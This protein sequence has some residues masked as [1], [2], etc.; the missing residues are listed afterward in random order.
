MKPHVVSIGISGHVVK[1]ASA[2]GAGD[3]GGIKLSPGTAGLDRVIAIGGIIDGVP[4]FSSLKADIIGDSIV[5]SERRDDR[6]RSRSNRK[7]GND[8]G[9]GVARSGLTGSRTTTS[10]G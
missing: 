3:I 5:R 1:G 10:A 4:E 7:S 2:A 6:K 8:R 9:C